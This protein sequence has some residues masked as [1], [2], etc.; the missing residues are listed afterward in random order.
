MRSLTFFAM[1]GI[2][3]F[4]VDASL[5]KL[6]IVLIEDDPILG[7][8][9]YFPVA[10]T[11]TWLLNRRYTFVPKYMSLFREWISYVVVNSVGLTIN[12]LVFMAVV[13]A[14]DAAKSYPIATLGIASLVAMFFNFFGSKYFVFKNKSIT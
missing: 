6:F 10:V 1:I 3:G 4:L 7:R 14:F 11:V 13:F 2:V 12:L 9:L 8:T 5:L